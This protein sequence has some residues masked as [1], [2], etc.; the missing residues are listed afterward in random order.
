MLVLRR[1]RF[2]RKAQDTASLD[3]W[4]TYEDNRKKDNHNDDNV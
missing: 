1:F 4:R 3:V 2:P